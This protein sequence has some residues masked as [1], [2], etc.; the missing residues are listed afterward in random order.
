MEPLFWV[1]SL[2]KSG[3]EE[4][5]GKQLQRPGSS[6][7][8]PPCGSLSSSVSPPMSL[9][10]PCLARAV[11]A[12]TQTPGVPSRRVRS[13]LLPCALPALTHPPCFPQVTL[14][15]L[16]IFLSE[17]QVSKVRYHHSFQKCKLNKFSLGLG[18]GD[19]TKNTL[20]HGWQLTPGNISHS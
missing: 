13:A 12:T 7:A 16:L 9:E 5:L 8:Q 10:Q 2:S 15:R 20:D 19:L 18:G 11:G 3:W 14:L 4:F 1:L 6:Q 17:K